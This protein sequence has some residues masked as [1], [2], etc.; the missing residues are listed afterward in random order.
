MYVYMSTKLSERIVLIR[1]NK[2]L[3]QDQLAEKLKVNRLAIIKWESGTKPQR[4]NIDA[5]LKAFP[6]VRREWLLEGEKPMYQVK[7]PLMDEINDNT[8]KAILKAYVNSMG[9]QI[10]ALSETQN[11]YEELVMS[12]K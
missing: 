7:I 10:K 4:A 1:K 8:A 6:D 11:H 2:Q 5:I 12:M 3:T 9:S